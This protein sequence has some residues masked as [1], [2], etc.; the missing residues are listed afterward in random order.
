MDVEAV[1]QHLQDSIPG[2]LAIYLFGS[3][4]KRSLSV[5]LPDNSFTVQPHRPQPSFR[6]RVRDK[7]T[8]PRRD[9]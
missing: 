8:Q 6:N 1:S 7:M 2:L 3:Y 5:S 9:E 4:A